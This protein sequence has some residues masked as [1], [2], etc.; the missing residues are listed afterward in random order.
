MERGLL[1]SFG[2]PDNQSAE[3]LSY[4]ERGKEHESMTGNDPLLNRVGETTP[5]AGAI[6]G[7]AVSQ[8]LGAACEVGLPDALGSG[9]ALGIADL[10]RA[11]VLQPEL[12]VSRVGR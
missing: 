5:L 6:R 4:R 2:E 11:L 9:D 12:R 1:A 8:M 10:A 7:L 3:P